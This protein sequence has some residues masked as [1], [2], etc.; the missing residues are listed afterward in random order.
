[1]GILFPKKKCKFQDIDCKGTICESCAYYYKASGD[2]LLANGALHQA[3]DTYQIALKY[4]PRNATI[5]HDLANTYHMLNEPA[6]TLKYA[7][8]AIQQNERLT[9]ALYLAACSANQLGDLTLA[10]T[11]ADRMLK[12]KPNQPEYKKLS[13]EISR[14]IALDKNSGD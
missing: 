8:L 2:K 9:N 11:Y 3:A 5:A 10:K 13:A 14:K 1:M 4:D 6:N 7:E 12:A